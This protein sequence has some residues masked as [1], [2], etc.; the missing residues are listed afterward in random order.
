MIEQV[1]R[2]VAR[3]GGYAWVESERQTACGSCSAKGCG[4]GALS[5]VFGKRSLRLKASNPHQE[6]VGSRVVVGIDEASFL[7]GSLSVYLVPLLLMIVGGGLGEV[8]APQLGLASTEGL[9]LLFGLIGLVS[10]FVW[11]RVISHAAE[12]D[13]RFEAVILRRQEPEGI[14]P[15][16]TDSLK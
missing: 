13:G 16:N 10:G 9:S 12:R 15:V 1:G 2:V 4:T 14:F 6:P 7:R 5:S 3:E 8:M 11:V